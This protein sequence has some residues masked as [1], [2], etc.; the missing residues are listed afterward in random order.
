MAT[1]EKPAWPSIGPP[2]TSMYKHILLALNAN[3]TMVQIIETNTRKDQ[4]PSTEILLKHLNGLSDALTRIRDDP[5]ERNILDAIQNLSDHTKRSFSALNEKLIIST[6][7]IQSSNTT[8]ASSQ[9]GAL[10]YRNALMIKKCPPHNYTIFFHTNH[11]KL[12]GYH[13]A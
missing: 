12:R 8:N 2:P 11:Q 6:D 3:Q 9:A 13:Q 5:K 10:S 4:W 7:Q 1:P